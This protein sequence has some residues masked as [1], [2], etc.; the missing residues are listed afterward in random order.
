MDWY[1]L[2]QGASDVR[3]TQTRAADGMLLAFAP[4]L[5]FE[6]VGLFVFWNDGTIILNENFKVAVSI[7]T[8]QGLCGGC[9]SALP[10]R[11]CLAA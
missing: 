9:R 4:E 1:V 5:P 7:M 2:C 11:P 10:S 8:G 6:Y 3:E